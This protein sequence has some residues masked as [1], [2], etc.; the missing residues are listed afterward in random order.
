MRNVPPPLVTPYADLLEVCASSRGDGVGVFARGGPIEAGALVCWYAGRLAYPQRR[1]DLPVAHRD[2]AM[3]IPADRNGP[4]HAAEYRVI[5]AS[6]AAAVRDAALSG[7]AQNTSAE[8]RSVV[9]ALM[10]TARD[11]SQANVKCER[12][13]DDA[14]A[15]RVVDGVAAHPM[16]ATRKIEIGEELLWFWAFGE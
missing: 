15:T 3:H 14:N 16:Y 4:V 6:W 2:L 7:D 12:D 1:N 9:G 13:Y 11:P 8:T 5:D 10:K